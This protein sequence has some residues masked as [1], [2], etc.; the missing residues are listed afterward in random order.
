MEVISAIKGKSCAPAP[1]MLNGWKHHMAFLMG[2]L[3]TWSRKPEQLFPLFVAKLKMLGDSQF[4]IYTGDLSP[5]EIA[6]ELEETLRGYRAFE[7]DSYHRWIESST[8]LF[9]Q[10]N[11]SDGSEWTLRQGDDEDHYIHIHPARYSRHGKRL[12]GNHL[13]TGLATLIMAAM[14]SE[15]PSLPLMNEVRA[16]FLGL[17]KVTKPMAREIFSTLNEFARLAGIPH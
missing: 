17:S 11:I 10:L 12:K 8:Q 6:S 14:R 2:Q 1:F 7:Q 5:T 9:W 13:R 4:D 16:N 3:Q 15:K